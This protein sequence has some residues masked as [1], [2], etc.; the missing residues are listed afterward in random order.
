VQYEYLDLMQV[1]VEAADL[2]SS[3]V[4]ARLLLED[5][6]WVPVIDDNLNNITAREIMTPNPSMVKKIQW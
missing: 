4:N 5:F 1:N 2:A 3:K 6:K